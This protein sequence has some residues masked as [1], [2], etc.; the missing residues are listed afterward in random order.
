MPQYNFDPPLLPAAHLSNPNFDSCKTVK[1][2]PTISIACGRF[3]SKQPKR[4]VVVTDDLELARRVEQ[5]GA[6][7]LRVGQFL[8]DLDAPP[9]EEK[10]HAPGFTAADFGLPE[11][12]DL[13][14]PPEDVADSRPVRRPARRPVRVVRRKA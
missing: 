13:D 11:T 7:S 2:M 6:S 5:L 12:V 3:A 4:F 8:A 1:I 14:R 10:R 9:L